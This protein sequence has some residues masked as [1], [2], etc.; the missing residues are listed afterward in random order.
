MSIPPPTD[1]LTPIDTPTVILTPTPKFKIKKILKFS[2][3]RVI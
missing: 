1:T 3:I 2:K